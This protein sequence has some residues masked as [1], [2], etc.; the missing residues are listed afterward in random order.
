MVVSSP[1]PLR[2][3]SRVNT[4]SRKEAHQIGDT[5]ALVKAVQKK[6]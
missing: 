3:S 5:D 4:G 1:I 2:T 6:Y